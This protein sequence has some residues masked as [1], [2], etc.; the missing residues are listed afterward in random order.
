MIHHR[1]QIFDDPLLQRSDLMRS[2]VLGDSMVLALRLPLNED[3]P[4][5]RLACNASISIG[6]DGKVFLSAPC[7]STERSIYMSL[8]MLVAERLEVAL[9]RVYLEQALPEQGPGAGE[10]SSTDN[11]EAVRTAL[12]LLGEASAT[13]RLM[14]TAAAAERWGVTVRSCHAHQGEVIHT[15]TLRKLKYG[16]LAID[17]AYRTIPKWSG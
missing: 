12:R 2:A 4:A 17:A 7:L 16:Q 11:P 5:G 14:L 8:K 9:N 3:N 13:A 1:P 6:G 10:M 15:P